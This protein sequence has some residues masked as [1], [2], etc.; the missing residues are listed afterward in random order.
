[1][2][3]RTF[4][5]TTAAQVL[6][7]SACTAINADGG[8]TFAIRRLTAD[9]RQCQSVC[10]QATESQA[11]A[12]RCVDSLSIGSNDMVDD[13]ARVKLGLMTYKHG[14]CVASNANY[15]CCKNAA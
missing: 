15:C 2:Q 4:V 9:P 10:S 11:Q 6:A 13:T 1:M 5:S 12:L 7:E 8:W 14:N 3:S